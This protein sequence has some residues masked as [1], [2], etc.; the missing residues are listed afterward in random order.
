[1]KKKS[2][3]LNMTVGSPLKNLLIFSLPLMLGNV[4]QLCYT[5]TDTW[6][7]GHF[8]GVKGLAAFG[9]VE[10]PMCL[11]YCVVMGITQGFSV[12]IAQRFGADDQAGLKKAIANS[13]ILSGVL[14]VGI[15]LF[16]QFLATPCLNLMKT[17]H[18]IRGL[19][20]LYLRMMYASAPVS[21]MANCFSAT[22]RALGNSKTPLKAIGLSSAINIALDFVFVFIF[23]WGMAG[24]CAAT[25]IA[26]AVSAIYCFVVFCQIKEI[27]LKK[28][29]FAMTRTLTVKLLVLGLPMAAQGIFL[30]IGG[31]MVQT[32]VNGLGTVFLAGYTATNKLY[33][34]MEIAATAL[35]YAITTYISQNYGAG[36]YD[37]ITRGLKTGCVLITSISVGL[38]AFMLIFGKW[39]IQR[40]IVGEPTVVEQAVQSGYIY[41]AFLA[42]GMPIIYYLFFFRAATQGMGESITTLVSGIVEMVC[43][44]AIAYI[45]IGLVAEY[46]I[47]WAEVSAWLGGF[48]AAF[49]GM[50]IHLIRIRKLKQGQKV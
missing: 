32:L 1:M 40:F 3:V 6:F 21:M 29:D 50:C 38:A 10:W 34:I 16:G 45:L 13:I 28:E 41:L 7:I 19:S 37:N 31:M 17:P 25:I 35:G 42:C 30:S 4:F 39:F 9:V 46:A 23:K 33:G 24:A 44:P 8:I 12:L 27:S 14:S 26:Q 43:R 18:E 11:F 22:L 15:I 49:V 2:N 36:K 20:E 5:L 48:V 47:Y